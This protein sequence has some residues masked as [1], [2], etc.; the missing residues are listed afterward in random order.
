MEEQ[1]IQ[2]LADAMW[3]YFHEK[4]LLPYLSDSVCYFMATVTTAPAGGV[5]GI[6]RPFDNTITLPYAWSAETLQAGDTCMVLVFGDLTN[7]IVIGKGDLSE[8]GIY[9]T[10]AGLLQTT[11]TAADNTMSQDAITD[12]L[13]GKQAAISGSAGQYVGFDA[14]GNPEA[15][16]PDAT[17]TNGSQNPVTSD[18]IFDALAMKAPLASPTLTG[19][20][21]APTAAEGTSTTQIATTAFVQT[22]IKRYSYTFTTSSWTASGTQFTLTLSASTHGCGADPMADVLVLNGSSYEKYYGYPSDGWTIGIDSSGN[23]T[24]TANTKFSGKIIVR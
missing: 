2:I 9:V 1:Q 14:N 23:I 16:S 7:A 18:G 15:K 5:I 24:L 13:N 19:T 20:P 12:A 4:Y 6:A 22:A 17:P 3:E 10:K 21:S 11:G 8:P